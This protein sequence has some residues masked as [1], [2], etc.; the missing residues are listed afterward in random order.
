LHA[1]GCATQAAFESRSICQ[2]IS[3]RV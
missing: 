3:S 2:Q 1:H